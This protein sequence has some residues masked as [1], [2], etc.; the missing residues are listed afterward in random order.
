[1]HQLTEDEFDTLF[2]VV[3]DPATGE[4]V[5]PSDQGP[6]RTSR[7]LWTIVDAD[8]DLH[9]LTGWHYVNR[10]GYLLTKEAWEEETEAAWFVGNPDEDENDEEN[11]P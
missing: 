6:D 1:M 4:D 8:G 9:A 3:P 7:H 10:V 2:T 11:Q 5:R